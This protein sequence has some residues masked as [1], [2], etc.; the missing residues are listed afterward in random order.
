VLATRLP[1]L[2]T[3]LQLFATRLPVLATRL[4][5]LATCLPVLVLLDISFE[6]GRKG[7]LRRKDGRRPENGF[8]HFFI[9]PFTYLF[10]DF[11]GCFSDF[12]G[13]ENGFIHFLFI[14]GLYRLTF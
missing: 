5:V 3:C 2:A 12:I 9:Y 10:I 14:H 6:E 4:P 1:V 8:I 13:P 7:R 11:I